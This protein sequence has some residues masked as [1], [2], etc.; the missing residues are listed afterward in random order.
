MEK[1]GEGGIFCGRDY[2]ESFSSG[3]TT[4]EPQNNEHFGHWDQIYCPLGRGQGRGLIGGQDFNCF[5][6]RSSILEDP[7]IRGSTVYKLILAETPL[8]KFLAC[9][10]RLVK[11]LCGGLTK[12]STKHVCLSSV[13]TIHC[14]ERKP[15]WSTRTEI[16]VEQV[17]ALVQGFNSCTL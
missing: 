2:S 8:I 9:K 6:T 12:N 4:M 11:N 5:V 13:R 17:R 1:R 7:F 10:D 15:L 14:K 16:F 3:S